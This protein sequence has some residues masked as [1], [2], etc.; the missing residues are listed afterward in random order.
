LL[1]FIASCFFQFL[2]THS[3][4]VGGGGRGGG[5]YGGLGGRAG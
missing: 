1:C 5:P 2:S 3:C 4:L